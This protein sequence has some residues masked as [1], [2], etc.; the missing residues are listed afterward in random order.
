MVPGAKS[1]SIA[2]ESFLPFFTFPTCCQPVEVSWN[3]FEAR[4]SFSCLCHLL[5]MRPLC[6]TFLIPQQWFLKF[7]RRL[8]SDACSAKQ[9]FTGPAHGVVTLANE[10]SHGKRFGTPNLVP[11]LFCDI[12][13]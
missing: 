6:A 5:Y 1:K 4:A 8:S 10:A 3:V 12:L 11:A 7:T 2:N 13:W 9:H